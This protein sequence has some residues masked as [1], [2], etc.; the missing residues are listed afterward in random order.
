M[1]FKSLRQEQSGSF[2]VEGILLIWIIFFGYVGVHK[3]ELTHVSETSLIDLRDQWVV[4]ANSRVD[5]AGPYT[6]L[7]IAI[8]RSLYIGFSLS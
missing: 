4:R 1:P 7:S 3:F 8:V 5:A 2:P 6:F